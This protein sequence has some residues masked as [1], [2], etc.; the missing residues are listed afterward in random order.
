[1]GQCCAG[2]LSVVP[3]ELAL[4]QAIPFGTTAWRIS[5]GRRQVVESSIGCGPSALST[6]WRWMVL[7]P[8]LSVLPDVANRRIGTWAQ[9]VEH[10]TK[11]P[12]G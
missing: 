2:I 12:P 10:R 11:A 4:H 5:M 9:V 7:L 6:T 1:M 8:I 3:A